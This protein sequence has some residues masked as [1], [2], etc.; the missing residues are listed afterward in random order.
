MLALHQLAAAAA[1]ASAALGF[2]G[3]TRPMRTTLN[4]V[5]RGHR[6][7]AVAS[8]RPAGAA[9]VRASGRP[10]TCWTAL[11]TPRR[12]LAVASGVAVWSST[13]GWHHPC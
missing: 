13:R 2:A 10:A 6:A 8:T 9:H 4:R 11:S 7:R 12:P 3:S 5:R 1:A